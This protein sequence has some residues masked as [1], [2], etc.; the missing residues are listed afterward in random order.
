MSPANKILYII[1]T[2]SINKKGF[3]NDNV[4]KK[5]EICADSAVMQ[6]L[7]DNIYEALVSWIYSM[8]EKQDCDAL[9][10]VL[11]LLG[12]ND[13]SQLEDQYY[14]MDILTE[15][16]IRNILHKFSKIF[17][18]FEMSNL[19]S[20][21]YGF[22]SSSYLEK[23]FDGGRIIALPH[24]AEGRNCCME[25]NQKW[26]NALIKTFAN[27]NEEVRLIMHDKDLYGYSG[28]TFSLLKK[29]RA[30]SL[31]PDGNIDIIVFQHGENDMASC[32][33]IKDFGEGINMLGTIF[34]KNIAKRKAAE[35]KTNM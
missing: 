16:L 30:R 26:I 23:E 18:E 13:L 3:L 12:I 2:R 1:T 6:F 10:Q 35:D 4:F 32:L 24:L 7:I 11:E 15:D 8:L 31:Y 5:K 34:S 33:E 14:L 17:T 22:P 29:D 9:P 19:Q 21:V 27:E 28:V 20:P 25:D